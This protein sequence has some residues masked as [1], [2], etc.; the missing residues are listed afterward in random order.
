MGNEYFTI[1]NELTKDKV[2]KL[3]Q[4]PK[5]YTA[6]LPHEIV[7]SEPSN[8]IEAIL[9]QP[10]NFM[11][12]DAI[13]KGDTLSDIDKQIIETQQEKL[14][15]EINESKNKVAENSTEN[16]KSKEKESENDQLIAI[17][18]TCYLPGCIV[19]TI[20]KYGNI[21]RH[22]RES[23]PNYPDTTTTIN[24]EGNPGVND[25][26]NYGYDEHDND[27]DESESDDD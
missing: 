18:T 9:A 20:D 19:H 13:Q 15:K 17:L 1:Q 27:E 3:I 2:S 14:Q 6:I 23:D 7:P 11:Y 4:P 8:D 5:D 10:R 26:E 22:F 16:S 12:I 25:P 21:I 24:N